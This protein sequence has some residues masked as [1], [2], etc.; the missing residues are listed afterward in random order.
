MTEKKRRNIRSQG[1][2]KPDTQRG[3]DW[4]QEPWQDLYA[5]RDP[6]VREGI[7][8]RRKEIE[9]NSL[10]EP[11]E[12]AARRLDTELEKWERVRPTAE[13]ME[14]LGWKNEEIVWWILSGYQSETK[15]I[16]TPI[17]CELIIQLAALIVERESF[18]SPAKKQKKK[19]GKKGK[20]KG[21]KAP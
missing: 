13:A 4:T 10:D 5:L 11:E 17:F 2:K 9:V 3:V 18:T 12:W 15:T 19:P 8:L 21:K 6:L 16:D 1:I 7:E 14:S 20:G